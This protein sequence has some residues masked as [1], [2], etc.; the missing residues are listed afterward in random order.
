MSERQNGDGS[1]SAPC[2]RD[3]PLLVKVPLIICAT[4]G[5]P[6]TFYFVLRLLVRVAKAAWSP[7]ATLDSWVAL[8]FLSTVAALF[9]VV[10]I[11]HFSQWLKMRDKTRSPYEW[12]IPAE[13]VELK[14]MLPTEL[15][16]TVIGCVVFAVGAFT[17]LIPQFIGAVRTYPGK[18]IDVILVIGVVFLFG[19]AMM[20]CVLRLVWKHLRPN[21]V[22]RLAGVMREGESAEF[23]YCFKGDVET[24]K[25]VVFATVGGLTIPGAT[26]SVVNDAKTVSLPHEIA[27]GRVSLMMPRIAPGCHAHFSYRFRTTVTFKSGLVVTSS[28]RIPMKTFGNKR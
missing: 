21:Y 10:P 3:Q 28:Y 26:S 27:S 2:F 14:R 1:I 17:E 12:T 25:E 19:I 15:T 5:L 18:G 24:V 20:A 6:I 4:V 9:L 11:I 23:E 16:V 22:V 13:G 7:E 8:V